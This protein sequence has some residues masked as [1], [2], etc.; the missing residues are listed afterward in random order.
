MTDIFAAENVANRLLKGDRL[1]RGPNSAFMG[2]RQLV[3]KEAKMEIVHLD[4]KQLAARRGVSE[5]G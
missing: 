4:Q 5:W 3:R 1:A 2:A